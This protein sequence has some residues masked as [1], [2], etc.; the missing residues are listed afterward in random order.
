MTQSVIGAT[1]VVDVRKLNA[2][3]YVVRCAQQD[4]VHIGRF[5]KE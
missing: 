5:V 1:M 2:G 4:A 3:L